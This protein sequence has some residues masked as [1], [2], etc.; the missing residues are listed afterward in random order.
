MPVDDGDGSTLGL[1]GIPEFGM[2]G[3]P[4][5]LLPVGEGIAEGLPL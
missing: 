5:T 3:K 1:E 4:G 2:E